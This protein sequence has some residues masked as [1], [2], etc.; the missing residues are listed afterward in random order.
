MGLG[1]SALGCLD[2]GALAVQHIDHFVLATQS[3]SDALAFFLGVGEGL[4]GDDAL[5]GV[6]GVDA[7]L[8]GVHGVSWVGMASL[9]CVYYGASAL[10]VNRKF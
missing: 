1:R 10:L 5:V 8:D 2:D 7:G 9:P 6:G 4:E 3:V